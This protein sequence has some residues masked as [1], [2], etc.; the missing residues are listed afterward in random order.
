MKKIK[1]LTSLSSLAIIGAS[2]PIVATS[3]SNSSDYTVSGLNWNNAPTVGVTSTPNQWYITKGNDF[4]ASYDNCDNVKELK[5]NDKTSAELGFTFNET[6]QKGFITPT[7][8]GAYTLALDFTLDNGTKFTASTTVV[9]NTNYPWTVSQKDNCTATEQGK[10]VVIT[11]ITKDA[12]LNVTMDS[13]PSGANYVV[14]ATKF[15]DETKTYNI[16]HDNGVL[17]IPANTFTKADTNTMIECTVTVKNNRSIIGETLYLNIS[18]TSGEMTKDNG[19][20]TFGT[21]QEIAQFALANQF[22][23]EE[24]IDPIN[25]DNTEE[26]STFI[27]KYVSAG[28][29]AEGTLIYILSSFG[30]LLNPVG[31]NEEEEEEEEATI[32]L[33]DA[34]LNWTTSG[35]VLSLSS[36][37]VIDYYGSAT[38]TIVL[39]GTVIKD[40]ENKKV[41][42]DLNE[43]MDFGGSPSN[44]VY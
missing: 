6:L 3:C 35:N 1:L 10:K 39:K 34:I 37:F 23:V 43:F 2:V 27:N 5:I 33:N 21:I 36:K 11:D 15:G 42:Y 44:D 12:T 41:H 32:A 40:S 14:N 16:T 25:I 17:T 24:T 38:I 22:A 9:V 28:M 8:K 20:V 18:T 31:L 13:I 30:P 19:L 29:V 4:I 26:L 7:K